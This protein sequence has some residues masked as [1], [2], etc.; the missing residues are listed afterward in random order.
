MP[1]ASLRTGGPPDALMHA[2]SGE[3]FMHMHLPPKKKT[4]LL[5]TCSAAEGEHAC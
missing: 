3:K 4:E 5:C 2:D 1:S